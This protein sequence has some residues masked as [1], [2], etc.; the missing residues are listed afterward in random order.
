MFNFKNPLISV[1][2]PAYNPGENVKKTLSSLSAQQRQIFEVI[3][4][5]DGSTDDS[6]E[7]I[8]SFENSLPLKIVNQ[9]N[10]GVSVARNTGIKL[11]RGEYLFFLDAD[12]YIA[13][14]C[15]DQLYEAIITGSGADIVCFG[16]A[17]V[18]EKTNRIGSFEKKYSYFPGDRIG[19]D[20]L[21]DQLLGKF[22]VCVSSFI[23]KKQLVD[24]NQVRFTPGCTNGEDLEFIYKCL[25]WSEKVVCIPDTLS[26][27]L[28]HD[29]SASRTASMRLFHHV[30]MM[31]RMRCF[32][33]KHG[34]EELSKLT[35]EYFIPLS[36]LMTLG[37]L[38][39]SDSIPESQK[40]KIF[41]SMPIRV[42]MRKFK[43]RVFGI[44]DFRSLMKMKLFMY[45]P[46]LYNVLRRFYVLR[47]G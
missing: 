16:Y 44:N 12:D 31:K 4:V 34:Y 8:S 22:S 1:I 14:D 13:P 18:Y 28:K 2:I 33:K 47:R 45:A 29:G 20:V 25:F 36:F 41:L 23:V 11:A 19:K 32:Y 9:S 43:Y 26:F 35:D 24:N 10:Q 21:M 39:G 30:G 7:H 27:Y 42:S 6:L 5:N 17:Y 37:I 46:F 38:Y 3:V 40:R 15:M